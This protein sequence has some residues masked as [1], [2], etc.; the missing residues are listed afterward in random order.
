[1]AIMCWLSGITSGKCGTSRGFTDFVALNS[2]NDDIRSHLINHHLSRGNV[3][4]K[5][6]I[7]A[8]AG[9]LEIPPFSNLTNLNVK[10]VRCL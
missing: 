3:S 5:D 6:L 8:R 4:E 10:K 1:M 9:L 7:L 2:C